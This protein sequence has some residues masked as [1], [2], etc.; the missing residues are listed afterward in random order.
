MFKKNTILASVLFL[1]LAF[2]IPIE[3]KYDKLFRFFSL[4]LIPDGFQVHE[5]YDKK[6]YFYASDLISIFLALF[7]MQ[8]PLRSYFTGKG[9]VYLWVIFFL[10]LNSILHSSFA[11]YPIPYCRLLQ[12][13]SP[14]LLF[15][16][17]AQSFTSEESRKRIA[18]GFLFAIAAAGLIQSGIAIAQY[19]HQGSLGLRL[20][21]E[22]RFSQEIGGPAF[23]IYDGS[24][25][26]FDRI[27]HRESPYH[28]I[29]RAFGTLPHPNVLGGFLAISLLCCYGLIAQFSR[30]RLWIAATLPFQFFALCTSYS[31]SALFGWALGTAAW[32]GWTYWKKREFSRFLPLA[33]LLSA[34]I[35]AALLSDQFNHRGGIIN[36]NSVAQNSDQIRH[37][38]QNVAFE[39]LK[40]N[41]ITGVGYSQFS[42][43]A[44]PYFPK[45]MPPNMELTGAHNIYL[46][47]AGETGLL[48][49]AALLL[50]FGTILFNAAR[51]PHSPALASLLSIFLTLLFIGGCDF[52]PLLF[53]QGK[54]LLFS[55]AGL[56]A[57]HFIRKE[58]PSKQESWKMFDTISPTYDRV[59][60]ILSLGMDRSWRRKA[61]RFLPEGPLRLLDLA[62]GTGDQIA[63]LLP[64]KKIESAVGI[65]LSSEMLSI[66]QKKLG[67]EPHISF[68]R[69]DAEELPFA[70][71]SFNAA[72]FSFGIRNVPSPLRALKEVHRILKPNG[73]ALILE[74]SLPPLPIRPFYLFYLR[75]I[76]PHLGGALSRKFSAYRYLNETIET[77]PSGQAFRSLMEEAGFK[78]FSHPM[79]FGAVTLYVGEKR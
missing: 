46:F 63:A 34:S 27:F 40:K 18:L 10:A 17:L 50:F 58:E 5:G 38:Y 2:A 57:A 66:A 69:A 59:N 4:T 45:D 9:A 6:I 25:W 1:L 24:R 79:A 75:H 49:L 67:S 39:M 53:Q 20:F 14:I 64:T 12:L 52:Y 68:Q 42:A 73:R 51:L 56:L 74:F 65:D 11:S 32:F 30:W 47:L 61:A 55:T 35:S 26:I 72:T 29:V 15:T 28:H 54:L 70:N 21:G 22:H 7:W 19:F 60:R 33:V 71:D 16:F 43:Q 23:G 48:S 41:P 3:H 13:L 62:T 31:R 78:A 8:R 37:V 44:A 77:F 76:L 36:Y